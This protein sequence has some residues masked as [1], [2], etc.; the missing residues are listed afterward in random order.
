MTCVQTAR[1]ATPATVL[2]VSGEIPSTRSRSWSSGPRS[3]ADA[4]L[5]W[6]GRRGRGRPQTDS[7][8]SQDVAQQLARPG[9]ASS[10]SQ[11]PGTRALCPRV[12]V[13]GQ[14][15]VVKGGWGGA[16]PPRRRAESCT[17]GSRAHA[18]WSLWVG[19]PWAQGGRGLTSP[20]PALPGLTPPFW[21]KTLLGIQ[22][23]TDVCQGAGW[24][25]TKGWSSGEGPV[26]RSA[27]QETPL[28]MALACRGALGWAR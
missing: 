6:A 3:V 2:A 23:P 17:E 19:L 4:G 16:K 12:G 18:F 1:P 13:T 20:P 5:G 15:H 14:V 21:P 22:P 27:R 24:Q 10:S 8:E 25:S 9:P 28:P 7:L 11:P 26:G